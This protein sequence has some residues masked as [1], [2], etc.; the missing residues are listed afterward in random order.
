MSTKEEEIYL[1][2]LHWFHNLHTEEFEDTKDRQ[3]NEKG[4]S[5]DLITLQKH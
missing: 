5:N 2:S 1:S 3:H 4:T